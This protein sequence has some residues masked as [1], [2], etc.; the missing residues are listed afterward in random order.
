MINTATRPWL[1]AG[2]QEGGLDGEVGGNLDRLVRS[3]GM[4]QV[5]E[6]KWGLPCREESGSR[7]T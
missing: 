5:L 6:G 3:G 7:G 4:N 1:G 2:G